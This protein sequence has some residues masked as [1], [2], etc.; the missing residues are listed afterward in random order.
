MRALEPKTVL[1]VDPGLGVTGYGVLVPGPKGLRVLDAGTLRTDP[2]SPLSHRLAELYDGLSEVLSEFVPSLMGIEEVYSHYKHPATAIV[3]AH[4]RGV[5]CLAARHAETS[6]LAVPA[7]RIK[8]VITGSGRASKEQVRDM[9]RDILGISQP[10][11]P[12]DVSDALAAAIAAFETVKR[13]RQ[14]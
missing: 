11:S 8:K 4:A 6:V 1:G 14:R 13:D 9:V 5:L 2:K 12:L 3:M 7:T 10:V